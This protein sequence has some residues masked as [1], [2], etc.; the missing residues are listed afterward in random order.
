MATYYARI[1]LQL[2]SLY[3]SGFSEVWRGKWTDP[4][5]NVEHDVSINTN[6]LILTGLTTGQKVAMKV[7]RGVHNNTRRLE[8]LTRV[9]S[10]RH[11]FQVNILNHALIALES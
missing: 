3:F 11:A 4:S 1:D 6:L 2:F 10:V 7:L 5:T 8:V 9:S